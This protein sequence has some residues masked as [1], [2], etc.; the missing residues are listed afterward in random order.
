MLIT[1]RGQIIIRIQNLGSVIVLLS[2]KKK[3]YTFRIP[4]NFIL[5]ISMI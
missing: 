3:E 2:A 4:D 1:L 5:E